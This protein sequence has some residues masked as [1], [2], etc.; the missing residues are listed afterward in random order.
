MCCSEYHRCTSR[1]LQQSAPRHQPAQPRPSSARSELARPCGNSS[2]TS[3]QRHWVAAAATLA[4]DSPACPFQ[5]RD[6]Y[7]QS[8]PHRYTNLPGKWT[9][10]SPTT[11]GTA[12]RH[13]HHS[14]PTS[15]N[16]WLPSR[17]L[18]SLC[19]GHLEQSTCCY[20][21]FFQLGHFQNC[22]QNSSLQLCLHATSLTVIHWRL[23]FILS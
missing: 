5:A 22:S 4:A 2:A 1:L 15:C 18:C 10:P 14:A 8:H 6:H 20:S 12:L 9:A 7:V 17:F 3:F 23:R 19:T 21:W 11:E 13:H 16:I